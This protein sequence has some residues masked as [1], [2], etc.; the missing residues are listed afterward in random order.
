MTPEWKAYLDNLARL[1]REHQAE[2]SG[3]ET[4]RQRLIRTFRTT[5]RRRG[6]FGF[7]AAQR[8]AIAR[9]TREDDHDQR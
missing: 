4:R 8:R 2:D 5:N 6:I 9:A 7:T 3:P 1:Q